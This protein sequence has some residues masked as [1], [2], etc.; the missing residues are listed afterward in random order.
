MIKVNSSFSSLPVLFFIYML[1]SLHLSI[2]LNICRSFPGLQSLCDY[3]RTIDTSILLLVQHMSCVVTLREAACE[4][5][6]MF[7]LCYT[8]CDLQSDIFFS[9]S[10]FLLVNRSER[11]K[12]HLIKSF[13]RIPWAMLSPTKVWA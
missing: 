13:S 2:I 11:L 6:T 3:Q 1:T 5:N 9:F 8:E 10:L 12:T 7:L 4:L